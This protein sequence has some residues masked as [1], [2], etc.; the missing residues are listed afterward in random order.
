VV[1]EQE[2]RRR[3][4]QAERPGGLEVDR[5]LE[6][7]GLLNSKL[8]D[9]APFRIRSTYMAACRWSSDVPTSYAIN[10]SL[11]IANIEYG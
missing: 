4:R 8:E 5:E 11:S 2:E 7:R 9:S 10:P 6:C 3:D 1:G